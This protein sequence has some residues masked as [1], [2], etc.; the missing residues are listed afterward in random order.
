MHYMQG[1]FIHGSPAEEG[2]SLRPADQI[3]WRRNLQNVEVPIESVTVT[4]RSFAT[5]VIDG[6]LSLYLGRL[7]GVYV[8]QMFEDSARYVNVFVAFRR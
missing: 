4:Q 8:G 1:S 2:K 5:T 3:S 6:R 7:N